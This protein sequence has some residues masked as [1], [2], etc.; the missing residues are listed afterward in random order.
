MWSSHRPESKISPEPDP[1]VLNS[2]FVSQFAVAPERGSSSSCRS[3][4]PDPTESHTL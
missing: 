2:M 4:S 1:R 3:C